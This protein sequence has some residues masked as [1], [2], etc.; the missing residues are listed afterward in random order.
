VVSGVSRGKQV[1]GSYTEQEF[2]DFNLKLEVN[3]PKGSN[4]GVYLKGM[5]EI[6][7]MDSYK[8]ELNRHNMGAVYSRITPTVNAPRPEAEFSRKT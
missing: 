3:V 7:V 8:Q 2:E 4:S 6:Q 1:K 5:Y